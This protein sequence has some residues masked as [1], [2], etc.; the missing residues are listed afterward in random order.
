MSTAD[1][2][3]VLIIV[4]FSKGPDKVVKLRQKGSYWHFRVNPED[5]V[6]GV[7]VMSD[8]PDAY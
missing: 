2:A 5:H 1:E 7:V 6:T 4:S 3:Q 8:D